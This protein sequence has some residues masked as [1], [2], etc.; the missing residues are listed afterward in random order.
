M[1][2]LLEEIKMFY[3]YFN[4]ENY[5]FFALF[6]LSI[7]YI[8]TTETNKKI[9]DFFVGYS[10]IILVIIWNPICIYFLN[11]MIN[12][13]A[14]YRIYYMLPTCITIAYSGTKFIENCNKNTHKI[15]SL[16]VFLIVIISYG[17]CIFNPGTTIKVANYYKLPDESVEVA[18]LISTDEEVSYKHAI[19]P[20]GMSSQIRQVSPEILLYFSRLVTNPKDENGN[21]LPHDT[22]DASFYEPVVNH[23]NG[24]VEYIAEICEYSK[25]N[26]VVFPKSTKLS[27]KMEDYGFEI[28]KQT[29]SYIIYRRIEGID[30]IN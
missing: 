3:N 21:D 1:K 8:F 17:E 28:Y 11:K 9:K 19:V 18:Y 24:N 16:A 2:E 15:V 6:I 29:Q 26:Y 27:Q 23:N 5:L 22:D 13:G 12:I 25:I 10:I 20:Y 30:T 7:L 14:M 4:N